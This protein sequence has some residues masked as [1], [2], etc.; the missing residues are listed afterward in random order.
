M[1]GFAEV[2]IDFLPTSRGGRRTP[3]CISTDSTALYRPHFRIRDGDGEVLGVEF[4]DG[5]DGPVQP[6]RSTYATVRFLYEPEVRYDA[7]VVGAQI[8]VLEGSR[9]VGVGRVTRR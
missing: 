4:V 9:V 7:L 2:L 8:E 6:G 3:I 5:P 1:A